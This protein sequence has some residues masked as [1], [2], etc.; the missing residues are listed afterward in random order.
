MKQAMLLTAVAILLLVLAPAR[1]DTESYHL[2]KHRASVDQAVQK[3]LAFLATRLAPDASFAS[4]VKSMNAVSGLAGMAFLSAGHTPGRGPY[5]DVVNRCI[6][7]IL[8]TPAH[9]KHGHGYLGRD[10]TH[11]QMYGHGIATLFLCEVSGMVD[12]ERQKKI[13]V[14][15]PKALKLILTAQAV[16]KRDGRQAGGWR[17]TPTSPDSDLSISGWNLMALRSARLNGAQVP[18]EAIAKAI[19]F[20]NRCYDSG[21]GKYRYQPGAPQASAATTAVGLLCRELSGHHDDAINRRCA[22]YLLRWA[23]GTCRPGASPPH[24][25]YYHEYVTYYA[26]QAAFQLGGAYWEKFAPLLYTYLLRHQHDDG[27]WHGNGAPHYGPVYSTSMYVLA[28]TVS[29]RQLPIYQR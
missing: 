10:N 27:K 3:A 15:L 22:A 16:P 4:E 7:F 21:V 18:A 6:D 24:Q 20:V 11:D 23:R 2:A 25:Q 12:P 5:G 8:A 13:D 14:V 26:S 28:L 1:A 17:Y 29:Y 9:P 19:G